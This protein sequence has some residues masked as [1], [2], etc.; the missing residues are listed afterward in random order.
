MPG[1]SNSQIS[2][3][4]VAP[5]LESEETLALSRAE[6]GGLDGTPGLRHD[7]DASSPST[8]V[9][10]EEPATKYFYVNEEKLVTQ[11]LERVTEAPPQNYIFRL[12]SKNFY[13]LLFA[14]AVAIA[15]IIVGAIFGTQKS[16]QDQE[17]HVVLDPME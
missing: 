4:P 10:K 8:Y 12:R 17:G 9:S 16:K 6:I 2:I 13:I 1:I 3:A 15:T 11:D 5:G 7:S 14:A